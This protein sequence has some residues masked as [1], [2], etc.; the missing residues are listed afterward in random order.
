[1]DAKYLIIILM[2]H[3]PINLF[4]CPYNT[5]ARKFTQN[6]IKLYFCNLIVLLLMTELVSITKTVS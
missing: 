1:M 2:L 5:T 3:S 4:A 6:K